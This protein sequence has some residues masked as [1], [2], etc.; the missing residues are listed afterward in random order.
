MNKIRKIEKKTP[1][2]ETFAWIWG[3]Y[4]SLHIWTMKKSKINLKST[5]KTIQI[6]KIY[7]VFFLLL[8]FFFS[9]V[10]YFSA[11]TMQAHLQLA[12]I[13]CICHVRISFFYWL[14][15]ADLGEC[16][17]YQVFVLFFCCRFHPFGW[18]VCW[19]EPNRRKTNCILIIIIIIGTYWANQLR[20][21]RCC[22]R[23]QIPRK[24]LQIKF[25]KV[26]SDRWLRSPCPVAAWS[27]TVHD[28]LV[29]SSSLFSIDLIASASRHYVEFK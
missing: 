22:F 16:D 18:R 9:T 8:F 12:H 26:I 11:C 3:L 25:I 23:L 17:A 7:L 2:I 6:P 29:F 20:S 1:T 10:N 5:V 13:I 15:S 19:S 28:L 24:C 14:V 4:I 21:L 27:W